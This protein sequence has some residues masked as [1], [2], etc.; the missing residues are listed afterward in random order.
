MSG[1]GSCVAPGG[2]HRRRFWVMRFSVRSAGGAAA[3]TLHRCRDASPS[4]VRVLSTQSLEDLGHDESVQ[5]S[6]PSGFAGGAHGGKLTNHVRIEESHR[7]LRSLQRQVAD[8]A[9]RRRHLD[10]ACIAPMSRYWSLCCFR[11]L[12]LSR[13][14][15]M[16]L[17]VAVQLERSTRNADAPT[18]VWRSSDGYGI[19]I[20][21]SSISVITRRPVPCSLPPKRSCGVATRGSSTM[22][23]PCPVGQFLAAWC[24]F[25][26]SRSTPPP[27][28]H[29]RS[30]Y[31]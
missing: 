29:R 11:F 2:G 27:R 25:R 14:H 20:G 8:R 1:P 28:P 30:P 21:P 3:T 17:T 16:G 26:I 4:L 10:G 18:T 19:G 31:L 23:R 22:R 6:S 15:S 13:P 24:R 9:D 12:M 7:A 5:G